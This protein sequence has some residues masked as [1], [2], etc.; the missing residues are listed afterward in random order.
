MEPTGRRRKGSKY[1]LY[2]YAISATGG[3]EWIV[4]EAKP[5]R[6]C[7]GR[8]SGKQIRKQETAISRP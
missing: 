4:E 3:R 1:W 5:L 2:E 8:R 6:S 7:E